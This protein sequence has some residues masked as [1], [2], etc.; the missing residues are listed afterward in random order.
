[1]EDGAKLAKEQ[2]RLDYRYSDNQQKAA[3]AQIQVTQA[4]AQIAAAQVVIS[5]AQQNKANHQTQ[6]DELQK[7]IDFLT[8]KFTNQDLYD[9]M[10]SQLSATYFQSY[11]LAYRLCKQ[12]EACYRFELGVPTSTFI[13]FGYWDSLHKGLL[14]GEAL[15]HDLRRLQSAYLDQNVRRLEISRF[16][17]LAQLAPAALQQLLVTGACD[18]DLPEALFDGDYPGH[19]NRHLV[20]M[21]VTVVYPN[22]GRFDN[23]KATLTLTANKV[24]TSTDLGPGYRGSARRRRSPL[25][26]FLRRRA[27]ESRSRQRSG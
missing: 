23:V 2:G 15:N 22:P 8:G 9:W 13:Q 5:I 20:R 21:S 12:V 4:Q 11:R 1:M 6:E 18:F 25:C 7:Q 19:Y 24:R 14:A 3:E 16:V 10:V 17:S 26:L 27:A